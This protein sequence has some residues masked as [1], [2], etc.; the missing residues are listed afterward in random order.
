MG[1][2]IETADPLTFVLLRAESFPSWERGL[3]HFPLFLL[4]RTM[5]SFPSWERGLKQQVFLRIR[6][7]FLVVP[8]VGTWIETFSTPVLEPES[9]RRSPRGNVD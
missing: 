8:L 4:F 6:S 5:L 7:V 9:C 1:T 2:W 3:K